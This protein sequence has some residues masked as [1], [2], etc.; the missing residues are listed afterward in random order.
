MDILYGYLR[1]YWKYVALALFLAA[2]NQI[3]SLLDPL[4]FRHIIDRYATRYQDYTTQQFL[5][6]VSLLLGA[7]VGVAEELRVDTVSGDVQRG[8]Q[9]FLATD[10]VTRLISDEEL[11]AELSSQAPTFAARK[12]IETVLARGAPDTASLIITKSI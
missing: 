9:F 10:G 11:A 1:N 8:D 7:A 12:L 5:R 2:T 4:I 3:F 6:G